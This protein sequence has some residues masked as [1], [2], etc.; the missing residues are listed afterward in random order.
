MTFIYE[1]PYSAEIY[2]MCKYELPMLRLSKFI[3]LQIDRQTDTSHTTE[4]I[5]IR[6]RFAGGHLNS[7]WQNR[8]FIT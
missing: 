6:R 2:R 4:I 5:Y 8:W 1:L 7:R 3:V